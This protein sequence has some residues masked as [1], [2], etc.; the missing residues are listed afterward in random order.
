MFGAVRATTTHLGYVPL[1]LHV[2]HCCYLNWQSFGECL[3]PLPSSNLIGYTMCWVNTCCS[4]Q[5]HCLLC[6]S[7]H[8][9]RYLY[10]ALLRS[11]SG[12][13][14]ICLCM[15]L[16]LR[17][18]TSWSLNVHKFQPTVLKM[19]DILKCF[20]QT[21]AYWIYETLSFLLWLLVCKPDAAL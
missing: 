10:G 4:L 12:S 20:Q 17:P 15:A 11:R 13:V 2:L 21:S 9:F 8:G 6:G 7:F 18:H 19:P 14:T 1:F 3:P 16:L 5:F